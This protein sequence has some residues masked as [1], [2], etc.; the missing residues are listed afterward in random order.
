MGTTVLD[1]GGA[2]IS[3]NYKSDMPVVQKSYSGV[4]LAAYCVH[5]YN[6][7]IIMDDNVQSHCKQAAI[8]TR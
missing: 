6:H 7:L 2:A 4:L 5:I 1:A 8:Y 3:S